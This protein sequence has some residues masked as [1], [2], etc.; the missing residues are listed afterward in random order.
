MFDKRPTYSRRGRPYSYDCKVC[1]AAGRDRT[2]RQWDDLFR[3]HGKVCEECGTPAPL[4]PTGECKHCLE[5]KG[6][7]FCST[8][9]EKRLCS[10]DFLPRQSSCRFC[11]PTE[12]LNR[13]VFCDEC[14]IWRNPDHTHKHKRNLQP[15][16]RCRRC[17]EL[18][19]REVFFS[20]RMCFSCHPLHEKEKKE[21]DSRWAE[22]RNS[23]EYDI[24]QQRNQQRADATQR[25]KEL[26]K[27]QKVRDTTV[28]KYGITVLDY[29]Q[30]LQTQNERCA[31]C[32]DK[33]TDHVLGVDHDHRTG[34]VRGLLCRR[35]NVAIGY[36]RDDPE[37]ADAAANYLRLHDPS[38]EPL[39][40]SER[41]YPAEDLTPN[42]EAPPFP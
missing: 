4:T 5:K 17:K 28:K 12:L 40:E 8:C 36:L 11:T 18:K 25:R 9:G 31:I 38:V 13:Y 34:R 14:K 35:C 27:A 1:K 37:L 6:F 39:P 32:Q 30:M 42:E 7:R 33:P 10:L 15:I 29:E 19:S 20:S 22:Y 3:K 21:R 16:L 24:D 41:E 23:P 26:T 2:D